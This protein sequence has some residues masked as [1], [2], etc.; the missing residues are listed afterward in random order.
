MALMMEFNKLVN[1]SI[2]DPSFI[3]S[4]R[5]K[6]PLNQK[7]AS[8]IFGGGINAFSRYEKGKTKPSLALVELLNV[9]DRH[10]DL[11]DEIR[12]A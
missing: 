7:E 9:L 3:A 1:T 6:L 2:V 8:E 12:A 5:K 10:P 11:L 4:V